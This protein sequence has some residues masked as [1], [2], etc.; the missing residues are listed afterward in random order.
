MIQNLNIVESD[1]VP[2]PELDPEPE[3]ELDPEPEPEPELEMEP[4]PKPEPNP[5]LEPEP[6]PDPDVHNL[7]ANIDIGDDQA[8][9]AGVQD[10]VN[11]P[12]MLRH[13]NI[14]E[15]NKGERAFEYASSPRM[16]L[17]FQG[18]VPKMF[19]NN[20]AMDLFDNEEVVEENY[21]QAVE[22]DYYLEI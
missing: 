10:L 13:I 17:C 3:P 11:S 21:E 1:P 20:V 8:N 12:D 18:N 5:E 16:T 22:D 19:D 6:E 9:W 14:V 2:E 4:E 7:D 15:N